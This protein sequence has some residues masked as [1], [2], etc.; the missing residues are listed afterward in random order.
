MGPSCQHNLISEQRRELIGTETL[1]GRATTV[2][3]VT[4]REG[5]EDVTYYEW[6]ADDVQIALRLARKDGRWLAD[7]TNLR[8]TQLSSQLFELPSNYRPAE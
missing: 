8:L 2:S 6:R 3:E 1:Q 4:V 7:Y 5:S